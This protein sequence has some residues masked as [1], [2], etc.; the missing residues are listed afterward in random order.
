ML[1]KEIARKN[2]RLVATAARWYT[3]QNLPL[4]PELARLTKRYPTPPRRK[5]TL[6]RVAHPARITP[7][8]NRL[9]YAAAAPYW[10]QVWRAMGGSQNVV[11]R[12]WADIERE[13]RRKGE[14]RAANAMWAALD[15]LKD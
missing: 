8:L 3:L 15:R 7:D 13:L 5:L 1:A 12:Q 14:T 4:P 10:A 11:N 6:K 9:L 2:A